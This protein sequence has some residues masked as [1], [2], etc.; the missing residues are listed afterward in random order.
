MFITFRKW[1][2]YYLFCLLVLVVVFTLITRQGTAVQTAVKTS[3]LEY[4]PT[5]IIDPGHG[6]E[7]GGAVASDGTIESHINLCIASTAADLA[8]FLGWK[9][10]MTRTEDISIH[11]NNATTLRE[12]KVSDLKNRVAICN[13]IKNSTLISI[14]QNSIPAAKNVRGAQVF[15]NEIDRSSDLAQM[16][17]KSLNQTL[18][19]GYAKEC[20]QMGE[21]NYLLRN[22][23]IPAIL[24]ECGFLSNQAET[25]LLKTH[26]HQIKISL[27]V[28]CAVT[29]YFSADGK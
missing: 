9:V 17:Q 19:I 4:P 6:G 27:C 20:K 22:V 21:S 28:I 14:H 29:N 7:D 11:D 8:R 5:L 18:N 3:L 16:V 15:F 24:I 13:S 25:Q 10:V 12:K 26:E 1:T 2:V 23:E